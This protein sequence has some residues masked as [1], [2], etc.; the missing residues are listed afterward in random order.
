MGRRNLPPPPLHPTRLLRA[1]SVAR[2]EFRVQLWPVFGI[3]SDAAG[4]PPGARRPIWNSDA[5]TV[6]LDPSACRRLCP[7]W[8]P[9]PDLA[10]VPSRPAAPDGAQAVRAELTRTPRTGSNV[11]RLYVSLHCRAASVNQPRARRSGPLTTNLRQRPRSPGPPAVGRLGEPCADA[12]ALRTDRPAQGPVR[13]AA[14]A[15]RP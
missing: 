7:G 3:D 1:R 15:S 14:P 10:Q 11:R 4:P 9:W 8:A 6:D 13:C 5:A 2:R 12:A